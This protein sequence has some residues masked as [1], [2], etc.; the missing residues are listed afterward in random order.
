MSI[1][2]SEIPV[3]PLHD[4]CEGIYSGKN[5][6]KCSLNNILMIHPPRQLCKLPAP[7]WEKRYCVASLY[8]L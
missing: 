5:T 7:Y 2:L 6:V 8:Q 3:L 4:K 1:Q